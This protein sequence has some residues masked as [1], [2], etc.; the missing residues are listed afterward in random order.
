MRRLQYN[1][2]CGPIV[3]LLV[4]AFWLVAGLTTHLA[5]ADDKPYDTTTYKNEKKQKI[6]ITADKLVSD[7]EANYVEFIGNVK[8]IQAET[9]ITA[10]RLKIFYKKDLDNQKPPPVGEESIK[11]IVANGNVRIKFDNKVAI[12]QQ[13]VYN[14]QTRVIVLSGADSKILSGNDYISG[15]KITLYRTDGRINV[16]SGNEKR[17]E[18]VFYGAEKGIN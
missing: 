4:V 12:T 9:I 16:E 3:F 18:A 17:V 7:N 11:K 8:A 1:Q 2:N 13:A 10:D 15:E 6:H 14:T 5:D